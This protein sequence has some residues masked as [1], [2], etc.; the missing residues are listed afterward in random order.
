MSTLER[1]NQCPVCS[2]TL[3]TGFLN[4][5]DYS[6]TEE[7]FTIDTCKSCGFKFTNP[8]PDINNIGRYY[9]STEYI[10]HHDEAQNLLS[11]VYNMVRNYTTGE[12]IKLLKSHTEKTN[13]SILDIGCG[14]GYFLKRCKEQNWKTMGTEPDNDARQVA[15][16]RTESVIFE[17]IENSSLEKEKFDLIT[18][19]HVLEHVHKLNETM[20]W[21]YNHLNSNGTLII[22][23]PNNHSFDAK[24]FGKQW[25]AYD[26]P[27]HLHHFTKESM[28][29]L[30]GLHQFEIKEIYPMWFDA[31]YVSMLS[32]QYKNGSK[33]IWNSAITGFISNWK[34]KKTASTEFNTSSLIYV[35]KKK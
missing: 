9:Q 13:P 28:Q 10:S 21:L 31:F 25:A 5:K 12:K 24:Q 14:T 17:S 3:L 29:R 1:L 4:V 18:M 30:L 8:R 35:V 32:N 6:V 34:G 22:A 19:W 11:R 15:I 27:R 23:L 20:E 7:I 2:S 33:N 16:N 26:V